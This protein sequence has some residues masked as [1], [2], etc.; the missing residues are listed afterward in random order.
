MADREWDWARRVFDHV[1]VN[2]SRYRESVRFYEIV[3]SP[4]DIPKLTDN[5]EA[6]GFTNLNVRN[7][8]PATRH[9]HI[10]FFARSKDQVDAFHRAGVEAGFSSN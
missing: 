7:R 1:D 9:L 6:A 2:A 4:L 5:D 8:A 10:C 3:F